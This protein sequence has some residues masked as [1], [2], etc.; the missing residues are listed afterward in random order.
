M[1]F[2]SFHLGD[3]L[4]KTKH[5]S[6]DED[7]AYR[8]L[9]DAYYINETPLPL[10]HGQCYRL[11]Q[12]TLPRHKAAVDS[13]LSEFFTK[14]SNGYCNFRCE[15]EIAAY[16]VKSSKAVASARAR[17]AA[18]NEAMRSDSE[19][20]ANAMPAQC[21]GN[22]TTT[23]PNTSTNKGSK[24]G[25]NGA[26]APPGLSHAEVLGCV[27]AWNAL[28]GERALTKVQNVTDLRT[29]GLRLRLSECG[30]PPGWAALLDIIRDSPFLLGDN[31]RG[32][33]VDF[34]WLLKSA[35]F[36]KTMEGKY[37]GKARRSTIAATLDD[38]DRGDAEG[39]QDP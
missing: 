3:Y 37:R 30:G 23:T 29:K 34:D 1:N 18:K 20:N 6:W 38:I 35:N 31:D 7:L 19:R 32:W 28:A 27:E 13:V 22:A 24:E 9:M 36:T 2:F 4:S 8:R 12:A 11:V 39:D 21:E 33:R 15:E 17:W 5:L 26:H 16:L 25:M 10:D 14:A